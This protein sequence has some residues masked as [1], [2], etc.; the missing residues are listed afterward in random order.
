[1]KD[2]E[3]FAVAPNPDFFKKVYIRC[4][5]VTAQIQQA[6]PIKAAQANPSST[7]HRPMFVNPSTQ[8]YFD[9]ENLALRF[10]S[11]HQGMNG[12][13]CENAL[14]K[15]LFGLLMWNI[16]FDDTVPYVFQSPYQSRPLDLETKYFYLSR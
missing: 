10:Y 3:I 9:V 5:T 8:D 6:L 16:I 7:L 2:N 11:I 14:G 1:M 12:M 13:H 15:T 4:A